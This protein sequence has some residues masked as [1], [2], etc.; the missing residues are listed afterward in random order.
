MQNIIGFDTETVLTRE[1][2]YLTHKF[3]SAQFYS[4]KPIYRGK[5]S[6]YTENPFEVQAM[7]S[8]LNRGAI[9]LALNAEFDF[10]VLAKILR[11]EP[12]KMRCLYNKSSFLYGKIV[13]NGHAYKIYDLMNIFSGW[14]LKKLGDFLGLPK[15]ENPNI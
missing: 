3:F 13:K 7:F 9:F 15:L 5:N 4:D 11:T 8:T 12:L 10:C 2:K 14:S 6:L 1:G